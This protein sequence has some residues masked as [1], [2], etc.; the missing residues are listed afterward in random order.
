LANA[1][2]GGVAKTNFQILIIDF[3]EKLTKWSQELKISKKMRNYYTNFP[4]LQSL[5]EKDST[6]HV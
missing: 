6:L 5:N 1:M 3:C 4:T 2:R